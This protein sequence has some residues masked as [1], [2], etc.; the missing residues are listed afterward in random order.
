[1]PVETASVFASVIKDHLELKAKNADLDGTMPITHYTSDDPFEN[2]PLFK[3]EEQ[4]RLEETMDGAE[5][6]VDFQASA[7]PWPGE[8]SGEAATEEQ[9]SRELSGALLEDG[10]WSRTRDF[11]WGD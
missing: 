1:M 10:L 5:P 7:L 6:A 9:A 3:S 4:A 2:H 8:T 11:D